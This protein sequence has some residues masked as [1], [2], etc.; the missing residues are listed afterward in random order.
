[1]A[2]EDGVASSVDNGRAPYAE[3]AVTDAEDDGPV[4]TKA[5]PKKS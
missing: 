2:G 1:L 4:A 3:T 5:P